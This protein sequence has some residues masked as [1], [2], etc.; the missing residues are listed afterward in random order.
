MET[1]QIPEMLKAMQE[2][3]E[4]SMKSNEDLL[5]RFGSQNRRQPKEDRRQSRKN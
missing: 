2:K 5:A 1:Q 4:A 3:E